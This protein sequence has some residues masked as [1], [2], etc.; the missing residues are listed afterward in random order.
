MAE[1]ESNKNKVS[2]VLI[3]DKGKILLLKRAP[4][5]KHGSK[6]DFPGG[7]VEP[8]EHGREAAARETMEETGLILEPSNLD[9]IYSSGKSNFYV[10]DKWDGVVKL[11]NEHVDFAWADQETSRTYDA[12]SLYN[13]IVQRFFEI[14]G[15]KNED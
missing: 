15:Q 6:W 10:T 7:H 11:S 8:N 9:L 5:T 3:L 14:K 12:G 13:K 2:N 1:N 4:G